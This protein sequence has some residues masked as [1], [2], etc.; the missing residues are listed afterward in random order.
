MS[1]TSKVDIIEKNDLW[2][3][4]ITIKGYMKATIYISKPYLCSYD[5]WCELA[6]GKSDI[7]FGIQNTS[8]ISVED[9]VDLTTGETKST[10]HFILDNEDEYDQLGFELE[11]PF[12][13]LSSKLLEAINL[14][15]EKG[16]KFS[17]ES[18]VL[19]FYSN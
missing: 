8:L 5:V 17:D 3:L 16:L 1:L 14:A 2:E 9:N 19:N 18:N 6:N 15:K 11:V 4:K 10:F 12:E 13:V 7:T